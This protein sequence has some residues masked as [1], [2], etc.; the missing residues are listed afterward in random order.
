ML[1][2]ASRKSAAF[3]LGYAVA[4]IQALE[5]AS[6]A[7]GAGAH[8]V[9]SRLRAEA[10]ALLDELRSSGLTPQELDAILEG[11]AAAR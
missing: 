8:P 7:S 1:S 6:A 9:V 3:R 4:S 10:A 11:N 5:T 2:D